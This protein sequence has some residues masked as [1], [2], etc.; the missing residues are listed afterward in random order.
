[1][2]RNNGYLEKAVIITFCILS[3]S[4]CTTATG[5]AVQ[6]PVQEAVSIEDTALKN[7]EESKTLIESGMPGALLH[8]RKLLAEADLTN[9]EQGGEL[10]YIASAL[11]SLIYPYSSDPYGTGVSLKSSIYPEL[12]ETVRNG[13]VPVINEENTSYFT[14][15]LSSAVVFYSTESDVFERAAEI[16]DQLFSFS[17]GSLYP[18]LIKAKISEEEGDFNESLKDYQTVLEK[19]EDC[20][21]AAFG[22]A[23]IYLKQGEYSK[24]VDILEGLYSRYPEGKEIRDLL[25][26]S[27]IGTGE[28][29]KAN[30]LLE[31]VLSA[32][33]ENVELALKKARLSLD[34]GQIERAEK[35]TDIFEASRGVS[36]ESLAIRVKILSSKGRYREAEGLFEEHKDL[37][38]GSPRLSVLYAQILVNTGKYDEGLLFL[39]K[40]LV[41]NPGNRI[42]SEMLLEIYIKKD[43]WNDALSVVSQLLADQPSLKIQREGVVVYYTMKLF[44]KAM[45]LNEKILSSG[46]SDLEDYIYRTKLLLNK[47]LKDTALKE[48]SNWIDK[49]ELPHERSTLYYYKSLCTDDLET[50]KEFLQQALFENLQNIDAIISLADLYTQQGEY[51]KAYRYLKQAVILDPA[52]S[53]VRKKLKEVERKIE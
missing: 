30:T 31:K 28:T 15:M 41:R 11:L 14:L 35:L 34:S 21:P 45:V 39:E 50:K 7:I 13:T 19:A 24:A 32:E 47:G 5:T 52:N 40:E 4:G 12:V 43:R 29:G 2:Q 42:L 44:N 6:P 9:T 10:D 33:P 51:R 1:M 38:E 23:V 49:S 17:P 18:L 3:V 37:L 27:Y 8:A 20:Y 48:L 53:A 46:E 26:D 36:A 16:A 22:E 25:I